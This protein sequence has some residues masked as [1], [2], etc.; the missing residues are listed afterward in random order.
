MAAVAQ[1]LLRL[2]LA[3][4]KASVAA[5]MLRTELEYMLHRR[6]SFATCL[7]VRQVVKDLRGRIPM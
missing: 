4:S 5:A 3:C 7:M 2:V 1:A 6:D